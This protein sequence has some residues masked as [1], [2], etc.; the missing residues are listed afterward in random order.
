MSYKSRVKNLIAELEQDLFEREECVRL[1]L[2]A[3]F[4]GKAIFL[5]GPPG[6]AKSMIARKVSLAFGAPKDF[7]S[8][9]MHRFSTPEDIFGPIDIGQLKQN[10]LVRNTKGYLST[11]SF[12]FL[13]EIFQ[14][15]RY[16]GYF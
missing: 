13:D 12:A 4:A 1:V 10:R 7:F 9:L 11:A 2:L 16:T 8:A 15:G 3:M 14:R 6:T 5:Y